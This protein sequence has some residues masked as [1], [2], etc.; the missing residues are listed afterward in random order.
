MKSSPPVKALALSYLPDRS[1]LAGYTR[2]YFGAEF[3]S[4]A[5]PNGREIVKARNLARSSGLT[6]TLMTPGLREETLSELADL[7]A[8]LSEDWHADD[9]LLISDF[10]V[11]ELAQQHLSQAQIILGRA[12]SGQKRGPRITGLSLSD[13]AADYFR[14]GSWYGLEAGKL[15]SESG[16]V[17]IELDNLLQGIAPVPEGF[18]GSLHTPWLMVT[19]SRNCPYHKDKSGK[20]CAVGCGEVFRLSTAE[21]E[22]PLYQAGNSQFV[23]NSV[24]PVDLATLGIDRV[25]EHL[26]LPR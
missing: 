8:L 13:A 6:F 24:L 17:R 26:S 9:E 21:T 18:S 20:R 23:Q 25:V 5:L 19:S 12:L 16:I 2:L 10:G 1:V 15:L 7:F 3:C 22:Y 14:Q 11:L 4:W